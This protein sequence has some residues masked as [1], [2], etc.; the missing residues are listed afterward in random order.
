MP[1][2]FDVIIIGSGAG[3]GTVAYSLAD[4]G[5]KILIL[6]QGGWLPREKRNWDPHFIFGKDGYKAPVE[7]EG[8]DG[9]T[10]KPIVYHRVGGNTKMYGALL[11]RQRPEDFERQRH[12][13]GISPEWPVK[14]DEFE[15]Y[16]LMA[17]YVMK[18]HGNEGEDKT[19]GP[20]S[21]PYPF[22]AFPHEG[23]IAEVVK[24]LRG[25]GLNVHHSNLAL[26]RDVDEP[27]RRPCIACNTCDPFPCMVHAKSDAET[28]LVR[29]ALQHENVH[30]WTNSRV[31]RLVEE[32][33]KITRIELERDGEKMELSADLIVVAC[34]AI[35]SAA[36]LLKSKV[37]NSSDQVG[38]NFTKHNQS[39]I[40]AIDPNK[41]NDVV[42]QKTLGCHDFY[43]DGGPDHPYP[44][45][46]I[47]LTGKAHYTRILGDYAHLGLTVEEAKRMQKL[48]VDFWFTSEDL[49]DAHNR[50]EWTGK[51]IKMNYR[52]NNRESHFEFLDMFQEKYLKKAGFSEFYRSTKELEFTWHQAGTAQF[53]TDPRKSVLDTNCKAWD[54]DNLYVVD[55]SFQPSQGATNPTLT[56]IANAIR[57]SEH[58]RKDW[59]N[60][61]ELTTENYPKSDPYMADI[62]EANVVTTG[63][64]AGDADSWGA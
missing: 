59:F 30:L 10:V 33:G 48:A 54:L 21:G 63:Y 28:A 44:L 2:D 18:I 49:P 20:R 26:N 40:S 6:E 32:K 11:H 29:P 58:L 47:Q 15:P 8:P 57:V 5:K 13:G 24:D 9:Q 41:P 17:E 62:G 25:L 22:K 46:T 4:T 60:E 31:D 39:G 53:G 35:N 7:W 51:G 50:I 1:N 34:G 37:A 52:P 43:N 27:W 23:R 45:G 16:Y 55:A 19:A 38:R 3:G 42:F 61:G 12:K 64:A 56:I 36:L 14:Y